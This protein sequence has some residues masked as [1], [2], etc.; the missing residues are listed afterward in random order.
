LFLWTTT[1]VE[2]APS[3][4]AP[5]NQLEEL[6][7]PALA[8]AHA[9]AFPDPL[10]PR[11]PRPPTTDLRARHRFVL[12]ELLEFG[13][14]LCIETALPLLAAPARRILESLESVAFLPQNPL[15]N[16]FFGQ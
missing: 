9:K 16:R 2:L 5:S 14:L 13:E 11:F 7:H 12:E 8:G 15:P 6:A 4:R 10:A 1:H 3:R